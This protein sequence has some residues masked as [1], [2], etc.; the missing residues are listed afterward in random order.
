MKKSLIIL[1]I[2]W[3]LPWVQADVY[4][5]EIMHSPTD[6]SDT[7]GEW[8]ELYNSGTASVD[9]STW[10]IDSKAFENVTIG[11]KQYIVVARELL[12]GDDTDNE[13]FEAFWGN[14]NGVWDE[15]FVAVQGAL[16]LKEED[17][18][19]LTDGT[20]IETVAYDSSFGGTNGKTIERFSRTEWQEGNGT[21]G[22]GTFFAG[23]IEIDTIE[24]VLI[25][26][27]RL[28]QI[29]SVNVTDEST[30]PG[31]QVVPVI[32]GEKSVVIQVS[33]NHSTDRLPTVAASVDNETIQLDLETRF[34]P[35]STMFNGT[36]VLSSTD[37][38]GSYP[39]TIT[40]EDGNYT[41]ST[42]GSFDYLPVLAT[43]LD[44][45]SFRWETR[46]TVT[47]SVHVRNLGNV[48]IDIEVSAEDLSETESI[49]KDALWVYNGEWTTL[50]SPVRLDVNLQ[51]FSAHEVIFRLT[52][53]EEAPTGT[54]EGRILFT[55]MESEP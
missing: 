44:T 42:N 31:F 30:K 8:M 24:V 41:V 3:V 53:P 19:V 27:E 5:T 7:E 20:S 21:P 25:V 23:E 47:E 40:V 1:C 10:T 29:V 26:E 16:S 43:E 50:L 17:T 36:F 4:I 11:P 9:L 22:T 28:L 38:A 54:Y 2:L 12:D 52:L 6:I 18:I 48:P 51:P 33:V 13:S 34:S 14:N 37:M 46:D 49:I 45:E 32:G 15:P 39:F 55:S 35:T